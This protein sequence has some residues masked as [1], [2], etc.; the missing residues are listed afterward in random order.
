M[1]TFSIDELNE[2]VLEHTLEDLSHAGDGDVTLEISGDSKFEPLGV[3]LLHAF[4]LANKRSLKVTVSGHLAESFPSL[5]LASAISRA[6]YSVEPAGLHSSQWTRTW[7]PGSRHFAEALF[8]SPTEEQGE[9]ALSGRDFATFNDPHLTHPV[10]GSSSLSALVRRWL[11]RRLEDQ[12]GT[13]LE[14]AVNRAGFFVSEF[15]A[16][17]RE[18]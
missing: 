15:V 14:Q 16:N 3:A 12:P 18:H 6:P 9:F 13:A 1:T 5:G 17:V 4:F 2:Q 11:F 7:T 10:E 8:A